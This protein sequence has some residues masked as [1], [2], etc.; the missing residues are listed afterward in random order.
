MDLCDD[1]LWLCR[2][3]SLTGNERALCDALQQR[4]SALRLPAP[5]RRYGDSL[6]VP[7]TRN[8]GG[9]KL[10]LIGQ[11]DVCEAGQQEAR[12]E[13]GRVFAPGASDAKSGLALMLAVTEAPPAAVDLSLVFHA[14]GELGFENSELGWVLAQDAEVAQSEMALVL[15]PTDNKLQLGCGGSTHATLGFR[16]R[17]GHS[18]LPGAGQNAIHRFASVL[19]KLAAFTT[20]EDVVDDL[21]WRETLSVTSA[22]GGRTGSVVP[23]SFE[24]NVHHAYG[25]S[26]DTHQSQDM[27][28]AL[29]DRTAAV[30]F[31]ELS[32]PARPNRTHPLILSLEASGVRA[33]EARQTWS[34]VARF[35]ALGIA[36]ANFGPGPELAAHSREEYV[37]LAELEAGLGILGR[38]LSRSS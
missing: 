36:A 21:R 31:E 9:P 5:I 16:G 13:A 11:L 14:R 24:V 1:L 20:V 38:W 33:V 27:L 15:K 7:L 29:V 10:A 6:V 32:E 30:R 35:S 4:L 18:G 34:E 23:S 3:P 2:I 37:E 22:H 12:L 26:T 8:S 25:P 17:T 28:L 19:S